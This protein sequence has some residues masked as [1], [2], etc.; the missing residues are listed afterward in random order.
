M[1]YQS[2]CILYPSK[3]HM[4]YPTCGVHLC[5]KRPEDGYTCSE[6]F[7]DLTTDLLEEYDKWHS[8]RESAVSTMESSQTSTCDSDV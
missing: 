7:Y 6:V 2:Q 5:V 3:A 8:R 4:E 1:E